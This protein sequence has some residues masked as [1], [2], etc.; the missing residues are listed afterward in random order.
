MSLDVF[1][2]C[3]TCFK[4]V[5]QSPAFKEI[6]NSVLQVLDNVIDN[7]LWPSGFKMK[8]YALRQVMCEDQGSN[9]TNVQNSYTPMTICLKK[10][11]AFHHLLPISER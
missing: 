2:V 6:G 3:A 11:L 10:K 9:K 8:P 5:I 1:M 7:G 4:I